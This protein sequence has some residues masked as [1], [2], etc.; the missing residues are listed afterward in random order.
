MESRIILSLLI[1]WFIQEIFTPPSG[2][3]Q[4]M[5]QAGAKRAV[6]GQNRPWATSSLRMAVIYFTMTHLLEVNGSPLTT[7]EIVG[8]VLAATGYVVR[9]WACATLGRFHSFTIGVQPEHWLVTTGPYA[10]V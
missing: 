5:Q 8:Y 10:W 4:S 7:W 1:N 9:Q 3:E 2:S 6:E